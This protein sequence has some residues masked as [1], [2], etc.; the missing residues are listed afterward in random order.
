M[1]GRWK[2]L[3]LGLDAAGRSLTIPD[4]EEGERL[5]APAVVIESE[6]RRQDLRVVGRLRL[7]LF[8]NPKDFFLSCADE[9]LLLSLSL[10]VYVCV[11]VKLIASRPSESM[12]EKKVVGCGLVFFSQCSQ[13]CVNFLH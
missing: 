10:S 11:C 6:P 13:H 8:V 5:P 1:G 2:A 9:W 4:E 3:S 12:K 7:F